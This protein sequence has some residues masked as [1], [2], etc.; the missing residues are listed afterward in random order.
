MTDELT[1][2]EESLRITARR[3]FAGGAH[4][5]LEQLDELGWD[6]LVKA[7]SAVAVVT[8]AEEQG[9]SLGTSRLVELE[10]ARVLGLDPHE[11][12]LAFAL[13]STSCRPA[14]FDA[15]VFAD[16]TVVPAVHVPVRTAL[17]VGLARF[18][19][20]ACRMEPIAG[21]DPAL[22]WW[23]LQGAI[24]PVSVEPVEAWT[25]AVA[26]G[27]RAVAHELIGVARGMLEQAVDHAVNRH[28]FGAPIGSFQAV[29]HRLAD[30]YVQAEAA[31][32]VARTA[33]AG[34]HPSAATAVL[35]AARRSVES[36]TEHCQQVLG[37][38]G[39]TWEHPLHRSIRRGLALSLLLDPEEDLRALVRT[40][41]VSADPV[42]VLA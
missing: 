42:E 40:A 38:M 7:E 9:Y 30:T 21:I 14:A 39:C 22:S 29:Q 19:R 11:N 13:R 8:L 35:A 34:L 5:G 1:I 2:L 17:G 6:E 37:A 28:Q 18:D 20:S 12:A 15:V 32:A 31:R 26:A 27:R 41:V 16:A 24:G 23:R 33:W 25:A 3:L 10:M 4:V 36:A